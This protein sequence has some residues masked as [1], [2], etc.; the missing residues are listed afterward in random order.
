[1]VGG[2]DDDDATTPRREEEGAMMREGAGGGKDEGNNGT[3][4]ATRSPKGPLDMQNAIEA[5]A[6]ARKAAAKTLLETVERDKR[7]QIICKKTSNKA[8]QKVYKRVTKYETQA[9][10]KGWI[11][12]KMAKFILE[13]MLVL[14]R[15]KNGEVEEVFARLTRL[16]KETVLSEAEMEARSVAAL[17]TTSASNNDINR[18][19]CT[20]NDGK[21][22]RCSCL[23]EPGH[24]HCAKHLKW[25]YGARAKSS[26]TKIITDRNNN[27]S[28]HASKQQPTQKQHALEKKSR[29]VPKR[30]AN[31]SEISEKQ[32][33]LREEKLYEQQRIEY[34]IR[35][36][37]KIKSSFQTIRK[38]AHVVCTI[39]RCVE[40]GENE[41]EDDVSEN[42]SIPLLPPGGNVKYSLSSSSLSSLS[43]SLVVKT[44]N[45][46]EFS[47]YEQLREH[48]LEL[49]SSSTLATTSEEAGGEISVVYWT[50]HNAAHQIALGEPYEF[51]KAQCVK[52]HAKVYP[53][54]NGRAS[55]FRSIKIPLPAGLSSSSSS[56]SISSFLHDVQAKRATVSSSL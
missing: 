56:S 9:H 15:E 47:G 41:D 36:R 21:S 39:E 20:R 48:L 33:R 11:L 46:E 42:T 37:K 6:A 19:R 38:S 26:A 7:F 40:N 52:L 44:I 16:V 32:E 51:F 24:K 5:I 2:E 55:A 17:P 22:W 1:M 10:N 14:P 18:M 50:A 54:A 8:L 35:M 34:K 12:S 3:T 23:A 30:R 53:N 4:G 49:A 45:L 25:G 28:K 13:E 31:L 43:S 27:V 29:H